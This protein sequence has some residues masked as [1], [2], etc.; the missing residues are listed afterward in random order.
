MNRAERR[1]WL[2]QIRVHDIVAVYFGTQLMG[3]EVVTSAP[4]TFITTGKHARK[5]SF[6]RDDG[7]MC[8]GKPMGTWFHIERPD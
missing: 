4:R 5:V 3:N 6:A 7:Y 2:A 1:E 8:G